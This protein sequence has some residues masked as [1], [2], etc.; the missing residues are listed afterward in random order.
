MDDVKAVI[1]FRGLEQDEDTTGQ[2]F[3]TD[4]DSWLAKND[5]SYD[6]DRSITRAEYVK[7][8]VRALSC[9]YTYMGNESG[10]SD[11]A[12]TAWHAPYIT[13]AKKKWWID[14]FE[15]GTF[16][17]DERITRAQAAKILARA[18]ELT[19]GSSSNSQFRDVESESLFAPYIQSLADKKILNGKRKYTFDPDGAIS[20]HEVARIVYKTFLGWQR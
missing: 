13:F 11:V 17:P 3:I 15:D 4:S 16:R 7:V 6:G 18:I 19:D 2:T 1:M 10:F 8:L 20:R 14:G 9:R 5:T 12:T